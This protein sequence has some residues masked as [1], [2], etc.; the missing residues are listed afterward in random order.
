VTNAPGIMYEITWTKPDGTGGGRATAMLK[1]AVQLRNA[2]RADG[3]KA[4]WVTPAEAATGRHAAPAPP[5]DEPVTGAA[6]DRLRDRLRILRAERCTCPATAAGYADTEM[7]TA[8]C[9]ADGLMMSVR[10]SSGTDYGQALR[11]AGELDSYDRAAER[12]LALNAF[13][14]LLRSEGVQLSGC[15]GCGGTCCTGE[16]SEACTC[17]EDC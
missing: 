1:A 15:R 10:R 9:P 7:H 13:P 6:A 17:G 12:N 8:G 5:V 2:L 3:W 11:D 4:V 16:G 14:H